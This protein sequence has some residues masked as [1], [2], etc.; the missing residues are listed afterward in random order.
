MALKRI[1]SPG[2]ARTADLVI[3][4]HPLYRL[5]YR[6]MK[7]DSAG[8]IGRRTLPVNILSCF[9]ALKRGRARFNPAAPQATPKATRRRSSAVSNCSMLVA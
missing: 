6:G 2:R 1:G 4:S 8:M 7:R 9:G 5:S 3:N